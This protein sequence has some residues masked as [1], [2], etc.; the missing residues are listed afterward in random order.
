MASD[1]TRR[2]FLQVSAGVAAYAA[3]ARF[4]VTHL[5]PQPPPD[6]VFVETPSGKLRGKGYSIAWFKGV[7]YA[8]SVIGARFRAAQSYAPWAGVRDATYHGPKCPQDAG[9]GPSPLASYRTPPETS[10]DCLTLNIYAPQ[11]LAGGKRPVM[12]WL[13]GGAFEGG[14]SGSSSWYDGESL[15]RRGDVVVVTITHRLNVFGYLHLADVAPKVAADANVGQTDIILALKWIRENIAAF[16]GDPACVTLFG[17]SGGGRKAAVLTAMPEA[18][19]LFHQMIAQSGAILRAQ[20]REE[21]AEH[22][23][24]FLKQLDIA[25]SDA[26]QLTNIPAEKLVAAREALFATAPRVWFGPVVDGK[27]LSAHPSDPAPLAIAAHIPLLIGSTGTETTL[28]L[29]DDE[30]FRLDEAAMRKKLA[31]HMQPDRVGPAVDALRVEEGALS[32]PDVFFRVT[33]DLRMRNRAIEQA[34]HKAAQ[35]APVYMYVT[36]W[37]TPIDNGMWRSPHVVDLPLIFD[38]AWYAPSMVGDSLGRADAM[39]A[40]MSEA[41]IAFARSGD[42]NTKTLPQWPRYD[43]A[44]RATMR[45]DDECRVIN[46]P[47]RELRRLLA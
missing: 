38:N 19:G 11:P 20:T 4:P 21:A 26:A 24:A 12:V 35:P 25:S 42:P 7:P 47:H 3:S 5:P 46:D 8:A 29:P 31:E 28:L 16:G 30:N 45:F 41:W 36:E 2:E 15:A 32:P 18:H 40:K 39:A 37:L 22:A 10:E 1:R 6:D 34:S 44:T 27:I 9:V 14:G 33:S 43:T 13:H 17:A 23:R